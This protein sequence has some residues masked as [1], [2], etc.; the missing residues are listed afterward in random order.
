M[1]EETPIYSVSKHLLSHP[2]SWA[3]GSRIRLGGAYI[4]LGG[5]VKEIC[6]QVSSFQAVLRA[7]QKTRQDK[8]RGSNW[9]LGQS[10]EA[11]SGWVI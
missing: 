5:D 7:E 9:E 2:P 6:K 8:G 10:R 11:S 3:L 4:L 1:K